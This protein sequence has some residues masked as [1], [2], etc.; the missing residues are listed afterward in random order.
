MQAFTF[1]SLAK[2]SSS[3]H[4]QAIHLLE[5]FYAIPSYYFFLQSCTFSSLSNHP[6]PRITVRYSLSF[7]SFFFSQSLTFFPAS[8][9]THLLTLSLPSL[10]FPNPSFF[11]PSHISYHLLTSLQFTTLSRPP[12][13]S[14]SLSISLSIYTLSLAPPRFTISSPCLVS[15]VSGRPWNASQTD[16]EIRTHDTRLRLRKD[17]DKEEVLVSCSDFRDWVFFLRL[18]K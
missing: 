6:S 17:E 5:S 12:S 16:E 1:F 3:R 15:G 14:S 8:P 11:Q 9:T 7:I 18:L 4:H 2:P 13:P 10:L